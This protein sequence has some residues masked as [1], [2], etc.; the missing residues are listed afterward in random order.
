MFLGGVQ[1][2]NQSIS[3]LSL[4]FFS[5][6]LVSWSTPWLW[7][8]FTLYLRNCTVHSAAVGV[9]ICSF[10]LH[11]IRSSIEIMLKR[12]HR[13]SSEFLLSAEIASRRF[14]GY[15]SILD[16][17]TFLQQTAAGV[18]CTLLSATAAGSVSRV[19]RDCGQQDVRC[20]PKRFF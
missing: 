15:Y 1:C 14:C 17:M 8:Y 5:C 13:A 12:R 9:I 16:T 11:G 7:F 20:V 10:S 18:D 6:F 3:S 4:F 2:C 19:S